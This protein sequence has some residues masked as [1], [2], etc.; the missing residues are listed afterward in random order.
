MTR[1]SRKKG[2]GHHLVQYLGACKTRII[3]FII[4]GFKGSPFPDTF[5]KSKWFTIA[6]LTILKAN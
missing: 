6:F 5:T 1:L 4:K 2:Y 3:S